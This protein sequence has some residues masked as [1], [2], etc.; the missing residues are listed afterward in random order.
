ML[1]TPEEISQPVSQSQEELRDAYRAANQDVLTDLYLE[2]PNEDWNNKI[3]DVIVVLCASR[4]GS[5]LIFNA[6]TSTGQVAAPGGEHEP[7]LTISENKFPFQN[8]DALNGKITNKPLLL[9]LLRSDLLV[10][11]RRLDTTDAIIPLRNRLVLR[12]QSDTDGF[13]ELMAGITRRGDVLRPEW[14]QVMQDVGKLA[15]KPMPIKIKEFGDN[16]LGLPLENPPLIDQPLAH[17]ATGEELKNLPI[18][19]KSPSDAYRLGFYEELFPNATI[20][21]IHLTRG[22][23]QTTNGLMDGW[24]K[25]DVDFIS[26]PVGLVVPLNIEDYSITDMTRAYWC[27]DLFED[28][29]S[30][31]DKTLLEV[32]AQQWIA[33]HSSIVENFAPNSQLKFENFYTNPREFYRQLSELTGI[34]TAGY[35][36][37]ESVMSTEPP[38]HR[39]WLKRATL[40]RNIRKY[41]PS[42]VMQRAS[43][44][45][46]HLGYTDDETTWH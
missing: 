21:Y 29:K 26:N 46:D 2:T 37:T 43:E 45:Q 3:S 16:A 8:S 27:F 39:R 20:N 30:Y 31:S 32:C 9:K 35:D 28:W 1:S 11:D 15:I 18:L 6:L 24:Q 42:E 14:N 36:W 17:I 41:L 13:P 12:G 19:F 38:S 25:N 22:F 34:D 5:S 44:L 40:F 7:W 33:A 4:S 10:R 23:I